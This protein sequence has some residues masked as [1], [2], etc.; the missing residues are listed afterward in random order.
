MILDDEINLLDYLSNGKSTRH[1]T[2][3]DPE[4]QSPE[5]ASMICQTAI[6]AGTDLI[7]IGGSTTDKSSVDRTVEV[8]QETMELQHWA[9]T[10]NGIFDEQKTTVPVLLFPNASSTLTNKS[11]G[12]LFMS[13][14]NGKSPKYIVEEQR[15]A[16]E[17]IKNYNITTISTAYLIFEPGMKVGNV[18]NADLINTED[19]DN[20][21]SWIRLAEYFKFSI[22]YLEAGSGA[23]PPLNEKIIKIAKNEYNGILF[24]GGG[25]RTPE[26][27]REAVN[28]GANWIVTGNLI[29]SFE[30]Y[31]LL[32]TKLK[33]LIDN[34]KKPP[35]G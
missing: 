2:L 13:L 16:T 4:K 29:E 8:I 34:I 32:K 11:D 5:E 18:S 31:N 26:Q 33:I 25:I 30:N 24:V 10:Q 27:A 6:E 20:I 12:I 3:I 14:L 19:T 35:D 1:A 9:S 22:L 7:L 15:K 21:K 23:F 17:F 28:G